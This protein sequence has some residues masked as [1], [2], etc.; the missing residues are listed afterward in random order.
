[1][2]R[3]FF[4]VAG[5]TIFLAGTA[6]GQSPTFDAADVH[7]HVKVSTAVANVS[8]G[9]V[10]SGRYDL[11][12]AT[13]VDMI[14]VA[15]GV[16][17]DFIVG[18]P[19]W[20]ERD[21]FDIVAK[22]PQTTSAE[23]V[24]LMLQALLADRFKLVIKNETRPM[25]GYALTVGKTG[26]HKLR[27]NNG[28]G[29]GCQPLQQGPPD[30]TAVPSIALACKN[31]TMDV[32][33]TQLIRGVGGYINV[34]VVDLTELK[35]GW[36]FELR[37]TPRQALQRAGADAITIFDAV[38]QQLGLKLEQ[39]SVPA[40]VLVVESVNQTPT[41]NAPNLATILPPAP[42]PEFDV[43]E[44][45]LS[46]P[47]SGTMIRLQPGGRI[48]AQGVTMKLMINL[49]WDI[50][51]D[52]RLAGLPKWAEETKFSLT[53]KASTAVQGTG[54]ATQADIDDIRLM[55]RAFLKERFK[56]ATH[57]E[58][59]PVTAY[60][61]I[62]DKPKMQKADPANR[63][64]WK[65]GPPPGMKDPREANPVLARFVTMRNMTMAQFTDDLPR[66]AGGYF[67]IPVLD[68]TGLD[69]AYDFTLSFS[70]INL[71][72][73]G[74]PGGRGGDAPAA[75]G[76]PAADPNGALSVFDAIN[77]QLGLK[78][79]KTKRPMPVLVID[80]LDEKPAD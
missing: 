26:K 24:K 17:P 18:G 8:G 5:L 36:D 15:Y 37:V 63:T 59:R 74:G 27:E 11:R 68:A 19:S 29:F 75:G 44:I 43:A 54:A 38:D 21:R 56:L 30:P 1:M 32:L 76:A 13:M 2:I 35:G 79:E 9:V 62:V 80:H 48:D 71:L 58:D 65:E 10:R 51:D 7:A 73:G 20:L 31:M 53:G 3:G 6:L 78:L 69:G 25:D 70:P 47:D 14:R 33:A 64:G 61:L 16:Q 67:R 22:A 45:K 34:P 50:N 28:Q 23:N 72:N 57:F 49:A 41:A 66:M 4:G 39:R 77:K 40:P 60:T 52:E 42:S 12:A 55:L 46:P